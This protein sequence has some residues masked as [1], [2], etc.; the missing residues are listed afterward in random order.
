MELSI[1]DKLLLQRFFTG[2]PV[3]KAYLFGS[4]SRKEATPDSDID[5]LVELDHSEPIGM[6]FFVIQNEL[7]DLL[8]KKIDLVSTGGISKYILP[9]I[10]KEKVLIYD[11]AAH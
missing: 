5:I 2:K 6:K 10:E 1:T 3:K 9:T 7:E 11:R 4:Y 8:H